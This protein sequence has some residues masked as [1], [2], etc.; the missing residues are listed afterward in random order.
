MLLP[1]T[2]TLPK[3]MLVGLAL[4]VDAADATPYP[5]SDT[6]AGVLLTLLTIEILP[7]EVPAAMGV[8]LTLKVVLW[9]AATVSGRE[10][11]LML[12]PAPV[13]VA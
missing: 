1:P 3:L 12:K 5:V 8:K 2:A 6:V 11:P 13:T 7:V 9:P 10:S 4:R